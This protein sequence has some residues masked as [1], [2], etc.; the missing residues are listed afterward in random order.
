MTVTDHGYWTQYVPAK[1]PDG[2]PVGTFL[3]LKRTGDGTDWYKLL[4]NNMS[5]PDANTIKMTV[6][7]GVCMT[8][9]HDPTVLVPLNV[10]VYEVDDTTSDPQTYVGKIYQ[11]GAFVNPLEPVPA[12]I[13]D[14]QFFQQLAIMGVITEDQAL[15]SNA[16][17][18]PPPLLTLIEGFPADQQFNIKMLVSG[19]V[20]FHRNNPVTQAI[21]AAYGWTPAQIDDFFKAAA[22]L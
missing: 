19:A 12:E 1:L 15:A 22:K 4:K 9:S 17:V 14:R 21:G 16:A 18:I 3:F 20:V 8:A 11:N 7:N 13:S 5:F 6:Q 10:S 2:I